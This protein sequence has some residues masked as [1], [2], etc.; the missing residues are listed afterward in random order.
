MMGSTHAM[1][2]FVIWFSMVRANISP[3]L[4]II[5]VVLGSLLP[6]I[7]HPNGTIRQMMDL[8]QFLK[9][10]I[11][12]I[13]PHRGPTHTIWAGIL[14]SLLTAGLAAWGGNPIVVSLA[15]GL[16]MF[17]GY[18]SHLILYS[19]NPRSEM[20]DTLERL[21]AQWANKDRKQRRGEL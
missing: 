1:A 14:F 19:L 12:T 3:P 18:S 9:H 17:I 13:I 21:Q 8:P 16:A 6:D 15:T 10:P 20:A 4:G 5:A 11:A 7:D 2:G